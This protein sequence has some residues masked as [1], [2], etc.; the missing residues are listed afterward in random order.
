MIIPTNN[1]KLK[2]RHITPSFG[3]ELLTLPGGGMAINT[4]RNKVEMPR[5]KSEL[6]FNSIETE[7]ILVDESLPE[8]IGVTPPRYLDYKPTPRRP[9]FGNKEDNLCPTV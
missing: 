2:T 1:L 7:S 5:I 3:R 9:T 8:V 4:S 6:T